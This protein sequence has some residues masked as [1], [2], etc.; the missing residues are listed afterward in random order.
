MADLI[1]LQSAWAGLAGSPEVVLEQGWAA[2]A[3]WAHAWL[4]LG[5]LGLAEG[6]PGSCEARAG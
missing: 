3:R 4:V 6:K 2:W 5:S 1:G